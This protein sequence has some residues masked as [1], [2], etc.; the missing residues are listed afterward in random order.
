MKLNRQA[1][2]CVEKKF[3]KLPNVQKYE[4]VQKTESGFISSIE[5]EDGK[6]SR[7][8]SRFFGEQKKNKN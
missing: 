1:I 3:S 7:G 4:I 2:E 6:I 5:M 8:F